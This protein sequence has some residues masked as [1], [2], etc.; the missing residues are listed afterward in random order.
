MEIV[1]I[2]NELLIGKISNTNAQWM[3]KRAT[4]LGITVRRITVVADEVEEIS[5]VI[6]EALQRKPQFIATTGGLGPTFDDKTLQG[7]SRAL[8][9]RLEINQEALRMVKEKYDLYAMKNRIENS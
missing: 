8:N 5:A 6:R 1:C 2:G 3:S 4:C 9:R 7:L